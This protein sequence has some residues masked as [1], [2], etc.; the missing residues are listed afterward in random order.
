MITKLMVI[1]LFLIIVTPAVSM[2]TNMRT[3]Q[4]MW[5]CNGTGDNDFYKAFGKMHC[6]GCSPKS[7]RVLILIH[8]K[9]DSFEIRKVF[10]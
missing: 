6:A 2:A 8:P 4:L 9:T 7:I 3:D 10:P 1:A 5:K